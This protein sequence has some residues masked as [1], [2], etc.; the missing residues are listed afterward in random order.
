MNPRHHPRLLLVATVVLAAVG[1]RRWN[2]L[3]PLA[4]ETLPTVAPLA[5]VAAT[6]S[7]DSLSAAGEAIVA[8]DPF[9]LANAPAAVRYDP[10]A[11]DAAAG[12]G[13]YVAPPA[14]RPRLVLKAIVGGPPW[15]AIIDGIPGQP[16]GTVVRAGN[17]FEKLTVTS[18]TRDEVVVH[19]MDT[20]WTL[21][22]KAA[23]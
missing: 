10:A 13:G 19:G 6:P 15:Q 16:A 4:A 2:H 20:V 5:R 23:P 21:S 11:E 9:R 18:V 14:P 7:D 17:A 1:A 22:F 3:P 12:A 8:N